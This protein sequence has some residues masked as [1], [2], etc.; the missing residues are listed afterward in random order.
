MLTEVVRLIC[1]WSTYLGDMLIEDGKGNLGYLQGV[2]FCPQ[3]AN[4][5]LA[6]KKSTNRNFEGIFWFNRVI[7]RDINSRK[8]FKTGFYDGRF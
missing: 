6:L 8:A 2:L 3:L 7:F 4:N 1:L 5:L